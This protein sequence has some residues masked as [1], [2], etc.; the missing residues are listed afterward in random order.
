MSQND[1]PP[2]AVIGIS[3][4]NTE[5]GTASAVAVSAVPPEPES[6]APQMPTKVPESRFRPVYEEWREG[7]LTQLEAAAQLKMSVRTFGRYVAG[8]RTSGSKWWE[9]RSHHRPSSR[10]A[11]DE[12]RTHLQALYSGSYLGW[13]VRHFYERYRDE[14]GGTRSY[15]WVKDV[16]Q[17]EGLVQRRTQ[18]GTPQRV[19]VSGLD[20]CESN[21]R[22][23][24]EGMLIHLLVA[25]SQWA[26]GCTWD[27]VATI[28]DASN[29]VYSGF[30]VEKLGIWPVFKAIRQTVEKGIFHRIGLPVALPAKLSA[31]ESAFGGRMRPQLGRAMS[32]LG[33]D[34]SPSG[35]GPGARRRRMIG[36]LRRRLPQELAAEGVAG[37]DAANGLL[38]RYWTRINESSG[39]AIESSTLFELL[40]PLELSRLGDIFCLKHTA[41][42]ANGNRLFSND[43]E[44]ELASHARRQLSKHREYRIHEYEDRSSKVWSRDTGAV[45]SIWTEVGVAS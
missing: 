12:E 41:R 39:K 5:S 21:G 30:F 7:R 20:L 13:N 32:E 36:T 37:I 33:I 24:R 14:H 44:V 45:R 23:P 34:M 19:S 11:P 26:S 17:S 15:S 10:R 16:L 22:M 29:C 25:R 6:L 9:G 40:N 18:N 28:D 3:L 27:L 1:P 38:R 2:N 35:A 43:M 31:S 42:I 4:G 8:L